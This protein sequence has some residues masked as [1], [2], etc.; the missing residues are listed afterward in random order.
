MFEDF[1]GGM[2]MVQ[3]DGKIFEGKRGDLFFKDQLAKA[4][5]YYLFNCGGSVGTTTP[6]IKNVDAVIIA[7]S[8]LTFQGPYPGAE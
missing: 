4:S 2:F 7:G 6:L 5:T 3:P 8:L 1:E